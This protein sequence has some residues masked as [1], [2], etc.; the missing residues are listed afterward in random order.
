MNAFFRITLHFF[1]FSALTLVT[2]IGGIVYLFS[3]LVIA[4]TS[5]GFKGK[6]GI[7]FILC[8]TIATY[9]IVPPLASLFGREPVARSSRT[10]PA[11]YL[12]VLLNRNY[13]V[14]E[15]N[16][17]LRN[18]EKNLNKSEIGIR[19]LDANFPFTK[20]F[21]LLPTLATVTAENWT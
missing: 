3:L 13:V 10:A 15:M 14:P 19:Y 2:Q 5:F 18:A 1:A 6:T 20:G 9:V 16:K 4:K 8:Y 7:F 11:N 17:L 21:P 12:T